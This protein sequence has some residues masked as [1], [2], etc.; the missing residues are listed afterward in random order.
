MD[1]FDFLIRE[2]TENDLPAVLAI[3]KD[4]F[5]DPWSEGMFREDLVSNTA[6]PFVAE[7]AGQIIGYAILLIILDDGHLTNI[8]VGRPYQRKSVAKRIVTFILQDALARGL[9]QVILEVRPANTAAIAL[10]KSFGFD[11]IS[12][13]KKY[14]R[15]PVEDCLVMRRRL[16]TKDGSN[17]AKNEYG[18]V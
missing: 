11:V 9:A 17:P 3:E 15:N 10:Y 4:L 1:D 5:T 8:A 2:M 18:L 12:R 16:S 14:Y 6:F 7:A 13:R